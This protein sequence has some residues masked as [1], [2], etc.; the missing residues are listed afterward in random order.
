MTQAL[1]GDPRFYERCGPFSVAE[2]ARMAGGTAA[3]TT[4]MLKGVAPLETAG[5]DD[6]S[7]LHD[8]RYAGALAN[9]HAGA[10]VVHPD[11]AAAVPATA[12]A[13]SAKATYEGWA[14]VARMFHPLP[15]VNPGIHAT[16]FVAHGATVDSTAEIGPFCC[17]EVGAAIGPNTRL[18][19]YASI[20]EG[21]TIGADCRIGT[22]VSISHAQLG[23]GPGLFD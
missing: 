22:H 5:Q 11:M 8:K 19:P 4:R 1:V 6:V 23:D 13:I 7:F 18:G 14:R 16:A 3:R 2:I 9:S 20:G 15:P 10:V 21:V 17:I 12:V